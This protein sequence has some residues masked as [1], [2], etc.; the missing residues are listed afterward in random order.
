[1]SMVWVV[2][3]PPLLWGHVVVVGSLWGALVLPL[4]WEV[5]GRTCMCSPM[6][7]LGVLSWGR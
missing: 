2:V 7:I 6:V 3:V 4:G 5:V 1:M